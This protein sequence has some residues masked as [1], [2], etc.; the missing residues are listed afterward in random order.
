MPPFLRRSILAGLALLGGCAIPNRDNPHDPSVAPITALHFFDAT[1]PGVACLVAADLAGTDH[2]PVLSAT[3]DLCL[4]LSAFGSTSRDG[5]TAGLT[6]TFV[7]LDTAGALAESYGTSSLDTLVLPP[8]SL[9]ALPLN[10]PI[11]FRVTVHDGLGVANRTSEALLL[12]RAPRARVTGLRILPVGG[13]PKTV[14]FG[15]KKPAVDDDGDVDLTYCWRFP[16]NAP[17]SSACTL[18][19]D[20]RGV[21]AP[22]AKNACFSRSIP[23]SIAG[24]FRA[25]LTVYDSLGA[26]SVPA[27]SEVRVG[28]TSPWLDAKGQ[29]PRR[30]DWQRFALPSQNAGPTLIAPYDTNRLALLYTALGAYSLRLATTPDLTL[31]TPLFSPVQLAGIGG[32][33]LASDPPRARVWTLS[34]GPFTP[35]WLEG[36]HVTGGT[37]DPP[38]TFRLAANIDPAIDPAELSAYLLAADASGD[39]WSAVRDDT[40]LFRLDP[41]TLPTTPGNTIPVVTPLDDGAPIGGLAA[42]P[43]HDEV[44]VTRSGTSALQRWPSQ[45]TAP[46][47]TYDIGTS[48][49]AFGPVWI[50][51]D[52]FWVSLGPAGVALVDVADLDPSR[53]IEEVARTLAEGFPTLVDLVADPA[54]GDLWGA[55]TGGGV[56]V[57]VRPDGT[58]E[59]F[60]GLAADL[61][62]V[63][64]EGLL[65][66]AA[67]S[68]L[69]RAGSPEPREP[70]ALG[71][72]GPNGGSTFDPET[73]GLWVPGSDSIESLVADGSLAT[74]IFFDPSSLGDPLLVAPQ[75]VAGGMWVYSALPAGSSSRSI[76]WLDPFALGDPP[77]IVLADASGIAQPFAAATVGGDGFLWV[78]TPDAAQGNHELKQLRPG[79][80]AVRVYDPPTFE[81][82]AAAAVS[83]VSGAACLGDL[84]DYTAPT[85][86]RVRWAKPDGTVLNV[87][88]V[89]TDGEFVTGVSIS[90]STVAGGEWCWVAVAEATGTF[91]GCPAAQVFTSRVRAWDPQNGALRTE[92]SIPGKIRSVV[93]RTANDLTFVVERCAGTIVVGNQLDLVRMT[94]AAPGLPFVTDEQE[95]VGAPQL[96]GP[97]SGRVIP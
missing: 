92:I 9:A 23:T 58:S 52:R 77:T 32:A 43:G 47:A 28:H 64:D 59:Q 87:A 26:A 97:S 16:A 31:D 76:A 22:S 75:P 48:A 44:W 78:S 91:A 33:A 63:D 15:S 89:A 29:T 18:T 27:I 7:R 71:L 79:V 14:A 42:R 34:G 54:S 65:W 69:T 37:F 41:A 40:R 80:A 46:L 51:A 17:P 81:D 62:Q 25:E 21:C 74:Q 11:A 66:L 39:V 83:D 2:T 95:N 24:R 5:S 35:Y 4:G 13:S 1:G 8:E 72:D 36:F 10:R 84:Y 86:V 6:F 20:A 82:I 93:A 38:G 94:R 30:F 49:L 67:A 85:E 61:L 90:P 12:N 96:L 3:N 73:G 70:V 53:P 55:S 88:T 19:A 56:V 57:H 50:D 60:L 68:W 45:G